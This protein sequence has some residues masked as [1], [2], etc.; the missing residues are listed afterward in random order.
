MLIA[1]PLVSAEQRNLVRDGFVY[2]SFKR[3]GADVFDNTGYD[4]SLTLHGTNDRRLARTNAASPATTA[5]LILVLILRQA[6]DE[7]FVNLNHAAK[8]LNILE[9]GDTDFVAHHPCGFV[10]AEA[11]EPHNLQCAHALLAGQ[12]KVDDAIPV[13]E[14]LVG[15]LEDRARKV[16]EAI[17]GRATG[18]AL[19]T[20]PVPRAR[21]Q[22]IDG[23]IAAT[24]S[25]LTTMVAGEGANGKRHDAVPWAEIG[26]E[27]DLLDPF[28]AITIARFR[29]Q[30]C[31][32]D[33]R[34]VPEREDQVRAAV[35][36]HGLEPTFLL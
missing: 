20:L 7:S 1:D 11:H 34:V 21:R 9:Q 13:T 15:I 23:G 26:V 6:A 25:V 19:G 3:A 8:L 14:R 18:G 35:T 31:R 12:H 24:R 32:P 16:R 10:R 17:A 29:A 30:F 2:E 22:V 5:A 33:W 36:R 4:V 28:T 27:Q